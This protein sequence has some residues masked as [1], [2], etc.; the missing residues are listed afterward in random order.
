[1]KGLS[2]FSLCL[3]GFALCA[4]PSSAQT[5]AN[6]GFEKMKT[7]IGEW[8]GKTETGGAA[9]ISYRLVSN[10]TALLETLQSEGEPEMVTLY[11][12]DGS[13]V[14]VTHYCSA[15][16]QPRMRT[17]PISASPQKLDFSFVDAT[18]LPDA[19]AGH[20]RHL[21]VTFEDNDHFTQHWT[22]QEKGVDK[23]EAFHFT[24]NRASPK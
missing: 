23:T 3:L 4:R 2:C 1:M 6:P 13:A 17:A 22:W 19:S 20:M 11:T 7:L 16:N 15:N 5:N 12:A 10:G 8:S 14:V 24:R 18:N 9:R 21:A